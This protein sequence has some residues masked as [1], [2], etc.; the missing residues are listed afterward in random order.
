MTYCGHI[1]IFKHTYS[2]SFFKEITRC[3][4]GSLLRQQKC[5][6]LK[7]FTDREICK[8]VDCF[9]NYISSKILMIF[10]I[11]YVFISEVLWFTY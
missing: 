3:Q 2:S 10:D 11:I 4:N 6:Y 1:N 8:E 7:A 9:T 5:I